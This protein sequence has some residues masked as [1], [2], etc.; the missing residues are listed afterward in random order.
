[1]QP[2]IWSSLD[3]YL[4]RMKPGQ[5]SIHFIVGDDVK[6]VMRSPHLDYF[7]KEGIEVLLFTEPV[8]SFMLMGLRKYKD[9][10]FDDISKAAPDADKP[11]EQTE[12]EKLAREKFDKLIER[13]KQVLGARVADVRSSK[14]LS[15]SVARL[16]DAGGGMGSEFERVY[17][18]VGQE[19][20]SAPKILELNPAHSILTDLMKLEDSSALQATIIEQIYDSALLVE[21]LHPDPSSI[22]P[23]VQQLMQAALAGHVVEKVAKAEKSKKKA[24]A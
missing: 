17:K 6:S 16:V 1:L 7:Q 5:K 22:V 10:E 4:L 15:Q 23:R 20:M 12:K 13:F 21:G 3:D 19:F 8:D 2:E 14:R 24:K 9:F 11:E 18:Y